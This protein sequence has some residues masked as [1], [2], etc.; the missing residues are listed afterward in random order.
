MQQTP[1]SKEFHPQA[2]AIDVGDLTPPTVGPMPRKRQYTLAVSA[3]LLT[4]RRI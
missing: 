1:F 4:G 2:P 3:G